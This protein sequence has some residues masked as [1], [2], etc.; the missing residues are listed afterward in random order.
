MSKAQSLGDRIAQARREL[1]VR[2]RRDV[3]QRDVAKAIGMSAAAVSQWEADDRTPSEAVI[4]KLAAY[5]GVTP[6]YL[7]YGI[8]AGHSPVPPGSHDMMEEVIAQNAAREAAE[9]E[10]RRT[11]QVGKRSIV[12]KRA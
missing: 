3:A 5:F 4:T 11:R 7:R 6:A 8:V 10:T 12:R 2:L 9:V 1:G